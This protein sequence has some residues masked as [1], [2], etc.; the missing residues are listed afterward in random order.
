[1]RRAATMPT[2]TP[3]LERP[4]WTSID[5]SPPV[6]GGRRLGGPGGCLTRAASRASRT[7]MRATSVAPR[8]VPSP[9]MS[10]RSSS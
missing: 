8:M 2:V 7:P 6:D 9:A 1:M 10:A 4:Q 5:S 3:L